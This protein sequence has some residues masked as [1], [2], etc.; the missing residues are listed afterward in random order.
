MFFTSGRTSNKRGKYP[1]SDDNLTAVRRFTPPCDGAYRLSQSSHQAVCP[2]AA[3]KGL[4]LCSDGSLRAADVRTADSVGQFTPSVTVGAEPPYDVQR[5]S[6]PFGAPSS[7]RHRFAV[8]CRL[9]VFHDAALIGLSPDARLSLQIPSIS[10]VF[11]TYTDAH[12]PSYD[13]RRLAAS[14]PCGV[15]GSVEPIPTDGGE[16]SYPS[17]KRLAHYRRSDVNRLSCL[18]LPYGSVE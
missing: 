13:S 10:E 15:S 3:T 5:R 18:I 14:T 16:P 6:A 1:F 2:R 4:H 9:A 7:G 11:G 12:T 17:G 8:T